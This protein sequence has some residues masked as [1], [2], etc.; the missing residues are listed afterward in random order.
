MPCSGCVCSYQ[1]TYLEGLKWWREVTGERWVWASRGARWG[2]LSEDEGLAGGE[3]HGF[4]FFAR[5]ESGGHTVDCGP[6]LDW[7]LATRG[8]VCLRLL[9]M[10]GARSLVPQSHQPHF[11]CSEPKLLALPSC[12]WR[13]RCR[14]TSLCSVGVDS[15]WA[16]RGRVCLGKS[17]HTLSPPPASCLRG[18]IGLRFSTD[19]FT[20]TEG[21]KGLEEARPYTLQSLASCCLPHVYSEKAFCSRFTYCETGPTA[22]FSVPLEKEWPSRTPT[23][24]R[25]PSPVPGAAST[26]ACPRF[27][28]PGHPPQRG[29]GTQASSRAEPRCPDVASS[30]RGLAA[31]S[32]GCPVCGLRV[33][34][35]HRRGKS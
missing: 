29:S 1:V 24:C 20:Q 7:P 15:Q 13:W 33:S 31:A 35:G 6:V 34:T 28:L 23:I 16:G 18:L 25:R 26:H 22:V 2:G 12:P 30:G 21:V 32:P 4:M 9:K 19:S 8:S 14:G 3:G 27:P 11:K 5:V 17:Q 10:D